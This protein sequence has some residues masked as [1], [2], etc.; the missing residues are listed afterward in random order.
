M[1]EQLI[2]GETCRR[3]NFGLHDSLVASSFLPLEEALA[4]GRQLSAYN[5][6][7]FEEPTIPE[8]VAGHAR[9]VEAL[10][11]PIAVGES[12]HS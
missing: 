6:Y 1:D 4:R 10:P 8:D 11:M 7:W 9:L 3:V 2:I 5:L 12:L